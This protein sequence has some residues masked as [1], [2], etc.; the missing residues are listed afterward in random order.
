M[1]IT[2]LEG[3]LGNQLFQY[4]VG[5]KL[6]YKNDTELKLALWEYQ[7]SSAA[8]YYRLGVFN[9]K[10]DF[11]TPEDLARVVDE[12]D[13]NYD[14]AKNLRH[15]N[16]R[17]APRPY[18]PEVI[19]GEVDNVCLSGG[20]QREEYFKDIADIIR[21]EFTLKNPLAPISNSWRE[22]ILAADCAVSL[23]VRRGDY[24]L[25]NSPNFG[26][27]PM[28]YYFRCIAELRK[29]VPN[30]TLFVFSNDMAWVKA[31]LNFGVPTEFVEGCE[32]AYEE[33]HLMSLCRHNIIANSSFSW[34]GAWLNPNPDKIVYMPS[35]Y[36]VTAEGFTYVAVDYSHLS[37]IDPPPLLSIIVY[38]DDAG[39][40]T[41]NR[42]MQGIFAQQSISLEVIVLDA[43][44]CDNGA[45]YRNFSA[46]DKMTIIKTNSKSGKYTA[47]NKG[48]EL[49]RGE[50][51]LF[52]TGKDFIF[53]DIVGMVGAIWEG[54][55]QKAAFRK[56]HNVKYENLRNVAPYIICAHRS[57][58]E[59]ASGNVHIEGIEGREF[60]FK[61]DALF[62]GWNAPAILQLD[63]NSKIALL[64]NGQLN[65]L[66]G[67]KIFKRDFLLDNKI[68]FP[69]N[70]IG[71]AELLFL[72]SAFLQ[73]EKIVVVP[74]LFYGRMD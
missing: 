8:V 53:L 52:L 14:P 27:L 10:A 12:T 65:N 62:Q 40:D 35:N 37:L 2:H 51:V 72:T 48:L 16:T 11:A 7:D 32:H 28:N 17:Y 70:G 49:A 68:R 67:T 9:I 19:A 38:A 42:T 69:E 55:I 33:M 64:V 6:A 34:W 13:E 44:I 50:Y 20:W 45:A 71:G 3:G 30:F 5:R 74:Q 47:W 59:N 57:I 23:H 46:F 1:I 15:I 56:V 22:K 36:M 21:Q 29:T 73:T 54:E 61:D 31:N 63:S 25:V 41:I 60:V 39:T 4:A 26:I 18:I 58:E 43:N 24:L 66:I